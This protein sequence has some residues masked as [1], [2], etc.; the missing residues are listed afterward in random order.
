MLLAAQIHQHDP[1]LGVEMKRA[2][3]AVLPA[4][5]TILDGCARERV[6]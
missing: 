1:G 2:G 5:A 4:P 6:A 3:A